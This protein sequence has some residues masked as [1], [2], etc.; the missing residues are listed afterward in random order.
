MRQQTAAYTTPSLQASCQQMSA[1]RYKQ[2]TLWTAEYMETLSCTSNDAAYNRL[3]G[4]TLVFDRWAFA[5]LRSTNSWWVT[6]YVG[7]PSAV[8]QPTRPTQP[9]GVDKWGVSCNLMLSPQIREGAI[10]WMQTKAKGRHGVVCRLNCVIHVWAPWGRVT[11]HLGHYINPRTFT[12]YLLTTLTMMLRRG[13]HDDEVATMTCN[14]LTTATALVCS[15]CGTER[16][17]KYATFAN[18]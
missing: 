10:W 13:C 2:H 17:V 5:V 11:C 14:I 18:T 1:Y 7:K 4:R 8:G 3:S 6:T 12:F 15:I 16:T 9:F